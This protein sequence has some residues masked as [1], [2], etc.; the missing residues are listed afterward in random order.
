MRKVYKWVRNVRGRY[1][2]QVL[3][4]DE[5]EFF[6]EY[7]KDRETGAPDRWPDAWPFAWSSLESAMNACASHITDELWACETDEVKAIFRT[8]VPQLTHLLRLYAKQDS[9]HSNNIPDV[10]Q[11]KTLRLLWRV[12]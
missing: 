7:F 3:E 6:L 12:A 5:Q 1:F 2:S 11:C 10:V 4:E 8:T 9:G